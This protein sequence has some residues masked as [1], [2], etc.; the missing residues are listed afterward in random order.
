M[1]L[2]VP[3]LE[4]VAGLIFTLGLTL[5]GIANRVI[6]RMNGRWTFFEKPLESDGRYYLFQSQ[7]YRGLPIE[8]ARKSVEGVFGYGT[9]GLENQNDLAIPIVAT[10]PIYPFLTSILDQPQNT[11]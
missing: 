8:E 2:K 9:F 11:V 1:K 3:N 4:W 6:D 10:R 5:F 7:R